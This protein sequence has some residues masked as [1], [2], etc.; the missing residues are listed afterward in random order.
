MMAFINQIN[1]LK[2][3]LGKN[4][5]TIKKGKFYAQLSY[6]QPYINSKQIKEVREKFKIHEKDTGSPE[7]QIA[8]LSVRIAYMTSHV[9]KNPKDFSSTRG[10]IAMVSARKKLLKYLRSQ[11]KERFLNICLNLKIRIQKD[12]Q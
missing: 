11:S 7:Y 10:L 5:S 3:N 4:N 6:P 2:I 12:L 9:K 1:I 8:A